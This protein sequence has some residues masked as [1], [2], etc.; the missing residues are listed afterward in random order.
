MSKRDRDLQRA[1][2]EWTKIDELKK[3]KRNTIGFHVDYFY[4][5]DGRKLFI[6]LEGSNQKQDWLTNFNI[7]TKKV[8][9]NG[10]KRYYHRGFH[11]TANMVWDKLKE[12]I[13]EH[14]ICLIYGYSLGG[15][16]AQIL[17]DYVKNCTDT[18]IEKIITFGAPRNRI[19]SKNKTLLKERKN[20]FRYIQ[21][22]DLVTLIPFFPYVHS[23]KKISLPSV[24]NWIKNHFYNF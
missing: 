5:S 8:T 1:K 21:G 11:Y 16:A 3:E 24:G 18:R 13:M 23:G 6:Y 19:Y 4:K 9:L 14:E 15:G 17:A 22:I 12:T 7:L 20:H 10:V 2:R